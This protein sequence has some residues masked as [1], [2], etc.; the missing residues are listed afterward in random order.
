MIVHLDK[1]QTK[2]ERRRLLAAGDVIYILFHD[3]LKRW[4]REGDVTL[5]PAEL[6]RSARAF[7]CTLLQLPEAM[8]GIDDEMDDLEEEAAGE[9]DAMLIMML[10]SAMLHAAGTHRIGFDPRQLILAIYGRW[11]NH[12]LF[13]P[14]LDEGARK[15]QARWLEGKRTD[16][17]A[18][19]LEE[20]AREGAG[21][22]AIRNFLKSFVDMSDKMDKESI[23]GFL[24]YLNKYNINHGN[25]YDAEIN[26]FYEKLGIKTTTL[27]SAEEVVIHK[28]VERQA[29]VTAPGAIGFQNE[30]ERTN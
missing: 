5:S 6:M 28:S 18:Y 26:L 22:E 24:L 2:Q 21:D 10:A 27:V 8:E 13:L 20:M 7:A 4:Q 25:K 30:S 15:E 16:L 12:P 11:G 14:F 23:K 19:E 3:A 17:L 1:E 29:V 9:S